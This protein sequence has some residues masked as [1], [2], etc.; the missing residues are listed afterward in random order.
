MTIDDIRDIASQER[1]LTVPPSDCGHEFVA[2][3]LGDL[4]LSWHEHARRGDEWPLILRVRFPHKAV[5]IGTVC[6]VTHEWD[7][8]S[9]E[10]A[11]DFMEYYEGVAP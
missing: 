11:K 7:H 6:W 10:S 2:Y 3:E 5:G 9:V 4:K 1:W 8:G